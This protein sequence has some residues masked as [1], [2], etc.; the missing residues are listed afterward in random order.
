MNAEQIVEASVPA[1]HPALPGH[2]PGRPIVPGVVLLECV[3]AAVGMPADMRLA[4]V[5]NLKFVHAL[6]PGERFRIRWTQENQTVRFRCEN[7][8][9]LLAQGLLVFK[10]RADNPPIPRDPT[11]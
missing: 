7:A 6:R 8:D 4:T 9:A 10:P 5:P 3:I 11:T 2:F 1:D